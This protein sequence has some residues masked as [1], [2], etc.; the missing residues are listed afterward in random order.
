MLGHTTRERLPWPV[1]MVVALYLVNKTPS[2][3]NL[4]SIAHPPRLATQSVASH[5]SHATGCVPTIRPKM[6][7]SSPKQSTQLVQRLTVCLTA[8]VTSLHGSVSRKWS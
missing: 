1:K 8:R 3:A 4:A 5:T 7:F 6:V 2:H